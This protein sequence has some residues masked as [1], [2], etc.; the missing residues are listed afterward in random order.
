MGI[1]E[2]E[3]FRALIVE[4]DNALMKKIADLRPKRDQ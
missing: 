4:M 3:H 1:D 2:F